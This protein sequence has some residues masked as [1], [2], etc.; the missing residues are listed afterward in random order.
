MADSKESGL[1]C[2]RCYNQEIEAMRVA[3][4]KS[5]QRNPH[6]DFKSVESSRPQW[7]SKSPGFSYTQTVSPTWTFGEG[8]TDG[9]ASLAKAQIEINPYA[10]GRPAIFNYKLMI[11]GVAPRPIAFLSTIGKHGESIV[12]R[13]R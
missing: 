10:P 5:I 13:V 4:E 7:R 2:N 12:V 11:S 1:Q 9:G 3:H 6:P 8:G